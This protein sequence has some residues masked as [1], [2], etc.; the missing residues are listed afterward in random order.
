[1]NYRPLVATLCFSVC[2]ACVDNTNVS[3]SPN[4][5]DQTPVVE[6]GDEAEIYAFANAC[7]AVTLDDGD[8]PK[9][10]LLGNGESFVF[11]ADPGSRF[12]MKASDLGTYLFYDE[13][14]GYLVAEDGPMLRQTKLDSD[15]YLVDDSYISG[16]EWQ[17][18]FS[19]RVSFRYQLKNRKTGRYLG[20]NG[21]VDSLE[22]A[23]ALTLNATDGC[24][25]HPEMSLDATGTVEPRYYDD[26]SI[27][28]FVDAHSHILANFGF[29][30][31]GIFHGA[32]FHRLGVEVA[33]GSC[34]PFH[35]EEGRAD[36]LGTGYGD[37]EP[38][39]KLLS[40]ACSAPVA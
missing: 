23:A 8:A 22:D 2:T 31:G 13:D 21:L 15:V 39:T 27:F 37:G 17:L 33:M 3:Q 4:T 28:G 9:L 12:F 20:V 24:T 7:V 19:Q 32:P 25:P 5:S 26:Q 11:S 18:E 38:L 34:E 30:G 1:M 36:L 40:S 14:R 35:A 29:G 16:A 10:D 6:H